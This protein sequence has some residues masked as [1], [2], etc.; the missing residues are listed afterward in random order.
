[1]IETPSPSSKASSHLRRA[2]ATSQNFQ[3]MTPITPAPNTAATPM[4]AMATIISTR[5]SH[6]LGGDAVRRQ[7][8]SVDRGREPNRHIFRKPT[9]NS[10]MASAPSAQASHRCG[11]VNAN[12]ASSA[13]GSQYRESPDGLNGLI[14]SLMV[15]LLGCGGGSVPHPLFYLEPPCCPPC[16]QEPPT[17]AQARAGMPDSAPS[18]LGRGPRVGAA[19]PHRGHI[20][21]TRAP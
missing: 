13:A 19:V 10:R 21:A 6:R 7:S 11:T 5:R 18:P 17:S 12:A 3:A 1:R 8:A 14:E 4:V 2:T 20:G 15:A 9:R 16:A